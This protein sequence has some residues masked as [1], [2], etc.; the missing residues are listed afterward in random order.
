M[1]R[2]ENLIF[3]T[4]HW[5]GFIG[6]LTIV[7][8]WAAVFLPATLAA[9]ILLYACLFVLGWAARIVVLAVRWLRAHPL[10]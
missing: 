2:I 8:G 1:Q 10:F 7:M 3:T 5:I 6:I 4:I 9:F